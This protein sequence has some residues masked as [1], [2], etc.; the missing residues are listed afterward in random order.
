MVDSIPGLGVINEAYRSDFITLDRAGEGLFHVGRD[1]VVAIM[2]PLD[3]KTEF[4]VYRDKTLV[5]VKSAL[6]HPPIYELKEAAFTGPAQA[7]LM[8]LDG[9]S[10]HSESF[11]MWI[12][13]RT[14]ARLLGDE[15]F[16]L[17]DEDE[18]YVSGHSVS[19]HLQ[20]AID[21]YCP[22]KTV[23]EARHYYFDITHRE[24]EEILAGRGRPN[25]FVPAPGLKEFLLT[26]KEHNSLLDALPVI[27]GDV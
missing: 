15:G 10:V 14:T 11:W 6:G 23:E 8:D 1:G 16:E 17:A 24:M 4:V 5:Y 27:L 7:V 18:P 19:E 12:I 26:L 22:D 9:T 21:K 13:E 25:A 2:A 3:R 20:Y